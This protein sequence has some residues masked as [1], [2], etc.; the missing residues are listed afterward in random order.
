METGDKESPRGRIGVARRIHI[1]KEF[2]ALSNCN[3]GVSLCGWAGMC[4]KTDEPADCFA[5]RLE[6]RR[7]K[8]VW[9]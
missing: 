7:S 6:E 1:L 9:P 4:A 8:E 5:C 3:W 2:Q